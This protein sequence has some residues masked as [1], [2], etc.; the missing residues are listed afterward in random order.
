[1]PKSLSPDIAYALKGNIR[2][3]G[4]QAQADAA[5]RRAEDRLEEFLGVGSTVLANTLV[6]T[7]AT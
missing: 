3:P 1:M 2:Y 5:E 4:T 6:I 7:P